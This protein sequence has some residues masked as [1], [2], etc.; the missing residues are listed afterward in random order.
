MRQVDPDVNL[1]LQLV[2]VVVRKLS[3][4]H[5]NFHTSKLEQVVANRAVTP[6]GM[7]AH[8]K[9]LNMCVCVCVCACVCISPCVCT[10]MPA[11]LSTS[12]SVSVCV[13]PGMHV[14]V[15]VCVCVCVPVYL[16]A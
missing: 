11:S 13:H 2:L 15:F 5:Q 14:H 16:S 10:G 3:G 7:E 9:K 6:D 4:C 12:P 8:I 1:S